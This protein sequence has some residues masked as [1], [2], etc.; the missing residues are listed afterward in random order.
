MRHRHPLVTMAARSGFTA[1]RPLHG[2]ADARRGISAL[3]LAPA[4]PGAGLLIVASAALEA[5]FVENET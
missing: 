3:I 1:A 4:D 2:C 5:R